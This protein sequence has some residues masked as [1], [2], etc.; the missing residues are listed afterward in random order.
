MMAIRREQYARFEEQA[1]MD[2]LRRVVEHLQQD[3]PDYIVGL[4]DEDLIT[5]IET[6][7][8]RAQTYG[9]LDEPD[10]VCFLDAGLLLN[11]E[12]F[13][14]NPQYLPI[15]VILDDQEVDPDERAEQ[16]LTLAFQQVL[17]DKVEA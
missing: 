17:L 12:R 2:F 7:V 6:S 1:W 15:R 10:V 3:L 8:T 14:E 9:L 5:R 11:D 4:S 13:P 16:V